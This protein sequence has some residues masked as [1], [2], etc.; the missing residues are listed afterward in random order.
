MNSKIVEKISEIVEGKPLKETKKV[1]KKLQEEVETDYKDIKDLSNKAKK[2]VFEQPVLYLKAF[3]VDNDKKLLVVKTKQNEK[4]DLPTGQ[5]KEDDNPIEFLPGIVKDEVGL[6]IEVSRLLG[7]DHI[8][9]KD[10]ARA[11]ISTYLCNPLNVSVILNS[12]FIEFK[13]VHMNEAKETLRE[14]FLKEID[15]YERG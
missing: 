13:W 15:N 9:D 8:T 11:S 3:I 12:K 2:F 7:V 5:I 4:W 14:P 1:I 10:K 6:N